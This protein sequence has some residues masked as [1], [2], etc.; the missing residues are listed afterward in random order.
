MILW[1]CEGVSEWKDTMLGVYL[2]YSI[3]VKKKKKIEK[4]CGIMYSC[5]DYAG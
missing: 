3:V 2:A 5:Q 4:V 1:L